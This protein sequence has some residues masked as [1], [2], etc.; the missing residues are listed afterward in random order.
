MLIKR[1]KAEIIDVMK[2]EEHDLDDEL[3]RKAMD[4]AQ[5]KVKQA[6]DGPGETEILK[7]EK[8]VN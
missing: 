7:P 5:K 1:G 6:M 8:L 2:D 4:H 3:T